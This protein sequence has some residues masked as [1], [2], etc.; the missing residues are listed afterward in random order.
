M[1]L[2]E[3]LCKSA[4]RVAPICEYFGNCGGCQLMHLR[5][6]GQLNVKR[7]RVVDAIQRIS[8]LD[9]T[10]VREC[11][12]SERELHYRNKIQVPVSDNG[13]IGLYASDSHRLVMVH[14]CRIH[15]EVGER[16]FSI[17]GE[18]LL[19]R[20]C[21]HLK[22]ILIR[23]AVRS[24]EVLVI[25]VTDAFA[26]N[27]SELVENIVEKCSN[28][29]GIVQNVNRRQDNVILGGEYKVLFGHSYLCDEI[30][31]IKFRVSASAF[32]Q[33]NSWQ[34]EQLYQIALN[35]AELRPE[36]I[37]LDAYCGI[38]V[39]TLSIALQVKWV[40]GVEC[41][42]KAIEDAKVNASLNN[43]A[44]VDFVCA[45]VEDF[46]V[47]CQH[48]NVV[49]LNPPRKGCDSR[50]LEKLQHMGV[51][52]IVYISCDPATL[53]RDVSYLSRVGYDL[54]K[55]QPIDMFPQTYHVE[56][57]ALLRKL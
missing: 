47:T 45:L 2:L 29:V 12:P 33:V 4:E 52:R 56:S 28:V 26:E 25:L 50:V 38:G 37:V 31:N 23:S 57:V 55:V 3:I 51:E 20:N 30:L 35:Y 17:I 7:Q 43:I 19:G 48:V 9:G 42:E 32:M 1:E 54:V 53:A 40:Y 36:D 27:L 10:V 14:S 41:I 6:K 49:F 24:D 34:A 18:L 16:V 11:L 22:Y 39:L 46:I 15:C 44:N 21:E 13:E 8:K 5:Y